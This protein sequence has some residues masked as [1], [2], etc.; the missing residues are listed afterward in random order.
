VRQQLEEVIKNLRVGHLMVLLHYG[1]MPKE[2]VKKNTHLFATE[3][4]PHLKD[5]WSEYEDKWWIK[6]AAKQAERELVGVK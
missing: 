5:M 2:T 3:V 1:N 4:M 6:P